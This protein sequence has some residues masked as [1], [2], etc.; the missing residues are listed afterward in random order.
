MTLWL[1][2]HF[3]HLQL[4]SL[5]SEQNNPAIVVV[6]SH[7]NQV[8]QASHRAFQAGIKLEMGLASAASLCEN[9]QV[10]AYDAALENAKL[11]EVASWLYL[12]TADISLF[13]PNGIV[14]KVTN[15]LSLYKSLDNYW[16]HVQN[17]LADLKLSYRFATGYSVLGARLLAQG[18]KNLVTDNMQT[19]MQEIKS[20]NLQCT[21]LSQST[22]E[23]LL[24]VR[25]V[26]VAQLLSIPIA[27]LAKRFEIELVQYIGRLKGELQHPLTYYVPALVFSRQLILLYELENL[28]WLTKPLGKLLQQLELFLRH[29]NKLA[30]QIILELQ[31]RDEQPLFLQVAAAKG[32]SSAQT[33]QS[34]L[35]LKLSNINLSS[36][37][38]AISLSVKDFE[39][40]TYESQSL[41]E[42][43]RSGIDGAELIAR[44][45]AKLGEQA[46]YGFEVYADHRPER[47]FSSSQPL[48]DSARLQRMPKQQRPSML[49]PHAVPLQE[50][51]T[52]YW[53]PERVS[54]GWWDNYAIERDYYIARNEQGQWLWVFKES[55]QR[56]FVHGLF[57]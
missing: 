50:K 25:I 15:M 8:M 35:E 17:H 33:W 19:L 38:Q 27:D 54:T 42:P 52:I 31:L 45:Q 56:W 23:K 13:P 41:F 55:S 12:V 5:L 51:V 39:D 48:S 40:N 47:S 2:I 29:R 53:G 10:V 43:E 7:T 4:D 9:L 21:E 22:C 46:V 20:F 28:Q 26:S 36:P 24:R 34:L 6:N 11:Q 44:L 30:M 32:E 16:H 3:E 57:C 37:V 1:Y 14:L 18:K 49:L